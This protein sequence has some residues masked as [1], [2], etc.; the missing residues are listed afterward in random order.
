M[1]EFF[2]KKFSKNDKE[3]QLENLKNSPIGIL[4]EAYY[5]TKHPEDCKCNLCLG[6]EKR[7]SEQVES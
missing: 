7:L 6:I 5:N 2:R 4:Y 3:K 1:T